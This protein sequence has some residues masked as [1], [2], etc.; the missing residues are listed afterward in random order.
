MSVERAFRMAH[1]K[2]LETFEREHSGLMD[3]WGEVE[4]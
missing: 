3:I 4:R 1:R 2:Y